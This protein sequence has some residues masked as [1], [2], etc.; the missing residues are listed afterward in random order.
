MPPN[1]NSIVLSKTDKGLLLRALIALVYQEEESI[2]SFAKEM[3]YV[4]DSNGRAKKFDGTFKDLLRYFDEHPEHGILHSFTVLNRL[5]QDIE[6]L[7]QK[8]S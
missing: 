7:R 3:I 5:K 4:P 1:K 2:V 6:A 8:L